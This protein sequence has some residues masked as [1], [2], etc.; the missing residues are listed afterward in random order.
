[1]RPVEPLDV[2][3][4]EHG[5]P[6][7]DFLEVRPDAVEQR[8]LDDAGSPRRGVAVVLEDVPSPEDQ[9]VQTGE[10]HD[11]GDARG[12]ALGPLTEPDGSHL[13][14][15]SNGFG[16]ALANGENAGN[17]RRADGSKADEQHADLAARGR[18]FY[19]YR[20]GR[21]LYQ[22]SPSSPRLYALARR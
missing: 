21:K 10:R 20:H 15:R 12:T 4:V 16:E 8:R 17:R 11:V 18:D 5:R 7:T 9:V 22:L 1:V 13:R 19:W 2:A 14:E 6:G 3:L